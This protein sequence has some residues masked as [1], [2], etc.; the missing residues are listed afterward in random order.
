VIASEST[1]GS[2][3]QLAD[4]RG[5]SSLPVVSDWQDWWRVW[6]PKILDNVGKV[7]WVLFVLDANE[8]ILEESML[9]SRLIKGKPGHTSKGWTPDEY[10]NVETICMQGLRWFETHAPSVIRDA[11]EWAQFILSAQ[12]GNLC[13]LARLGREQRSLQETGY[14]TVVLEQRD[15]GM[16]CTKGGDR[17]LEEVA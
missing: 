7:G 9:L 17:F 13:V 6:G 5:L 12:Y 15:D 14:S 8:K 10:G 3:T 1:R 2:L 11:P 16:H 4:N